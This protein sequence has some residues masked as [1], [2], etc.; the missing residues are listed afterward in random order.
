MIEGLL[1]AIFRL[2]SNISG[3]VLTVTYASK[4]FRLLKHL[5]APSENHAFQCFPCGPDAVSAPTSPCPVFPAP[6]RAPSQ[7]AT[8]RMGRATCA[9]G[10]SFAAQGAAS[11]LGKVLL[12]EAAALEEDSEPRSEGSSPAFTGSSRGD[13][14]TTSPAPAP[15]P[16]C[17][18]A[19]VVRLGTCVSPC[20]PC[21]L[22]ASVSAALPLGPYSC[23]PVFLGG[24]LGNSEL[25]GL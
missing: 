15:R 17:S 22:L 4:Y 20:F 5:A 9:S 1:E 24:V 7:R 14:G 10:S 3:V 6:G 18:E 23:P 25:R 8:D 12:G 16:L 19:V 13:V 2:N 11:L 21:L